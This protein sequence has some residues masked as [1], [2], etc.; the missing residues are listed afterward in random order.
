MT[1]HRLPCRGCKNAE[2][3]VISTPLFKTNGYYT[4]QQMNVLSIYCKLQKTMV[5]YPYEKCKLNNSKTTEGKQ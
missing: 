1:A 4:M 2:I 3:T 5:K